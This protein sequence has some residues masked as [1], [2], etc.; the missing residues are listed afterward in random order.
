MVAVPVEEYGG[1]R[2]EFESLV[3][4]AG[5][6]DLHQ[7]FTFPSMG[8]DEV[9]LFRAFDSERIAQHKPFWTPHCAFADPNAGADAPPRQSVEMRAICI[10]A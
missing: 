8:R 10:F 4:L 5:N 6:T 7:W 1:A 9:L 3:L 2:T